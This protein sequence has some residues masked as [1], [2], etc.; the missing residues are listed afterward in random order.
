MSYDFG[1]VCHEELRPTGDTCHPYECGVCTLRFTTETPR[2]G[3][4]EA[5]G[6]GG[7][8]CHPSLPVWP[9][10]LKETK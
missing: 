8:A 6:P 4:F 10:H 3:N 5:T 9:S 1:H 2:P 7:C